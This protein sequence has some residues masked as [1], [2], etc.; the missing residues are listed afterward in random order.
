MLE[1]RGLVKSYGPQR[2]IDD[3]SFDVAQGEIFGIL[4]PNGAGKTTTIEICEGVREADRGHVRLLGSD[5]YRFTK[6]MRNQI[7]IVAQSGFERTSLTVREMVTQFAAYSENPWDV[8]ELLEITG[9]GDKGGSRIGALSGGQRRRL[10]VA[11]GIVSRPRVLFLDEPTT[12]FDPAA[13]RAFWHLIRSL[14]DFGATIVLTSH[15]LEEV[16][17]LA[18]RIAILKAG[19]IVAAGTLPEIRQAVGAEATISWRGANGLQA[20][21]VT[22][23]LPFIRQLLSTCNDDEIADLEIRRPS[24]EDIYLELAIGKSYA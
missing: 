12:G 7:G 2:V 16:E 5:P 18:D 15:Y 10:D 17:F 6:M 9:L 23:V 19:R 14:R 3:V 20:E 1:V 11:L 24:L 4:G 13:R 8:D 22:E 21:T